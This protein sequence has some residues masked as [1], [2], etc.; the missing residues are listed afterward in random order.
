[1]QLCFI[2]VIYLLNKDSMISSWY[3]VHGLIW[4]KWDYALLW[5]IIYEPWTRVE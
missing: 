2:D 5:T 1:M 3:I 4:Y